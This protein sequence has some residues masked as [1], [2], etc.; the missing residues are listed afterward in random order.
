MT[1]RLVWDQCSQEQWNSYLAEV[2]YSTYLQTWEYGEAARKTTGQTPR[3][4]VIYKG[5]RP[6]GIAQVTQ[7]KQALGLVQMIRL[8]RGPLWLSAKAEKRDKFFSYHLLRQELRQGVKQIL[9][10]MP[11]MEDTPETQVI[12]KELTFSQAMQGH[13]TILLDLSPSI[14]EL[15]QNLKGKWRNCLNFATKHT[16]DL[17]VYEAKDFVSLDTLLQRYKRQKIKKMFTG[18]PADFIK[19]YIEETQFPYLHLSVHCPGTGDLLAESLVVT[20]GNSATYLIGYTSPK[21]R[22]LKANHMILW[23]N[24]VRLKAMGVTMFDLGGIK[25]K[26]ANGVTRFKSGLGGTEIT[27][28][29]VY[30]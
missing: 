28:A 5:R 20:H 17:K 2:P 26:R 30:V 10:I 12:M 29:G 1:L 8:M 18:P 22:V 14:E 9:S 4:C 7:K 25:M 21:G 27:L 15:R 24:I 16:L 3:R 23:E 13:S 11:E 6:L 19:A